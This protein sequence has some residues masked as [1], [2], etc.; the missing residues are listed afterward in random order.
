MLAILAI[1]DY[2]V[3]VNLLLIILGFFIGIYLIR[4]H[5]S[6]SSRKACNELNRPHE[7]VYT[8]PDHEELCCQVCGRKPGDY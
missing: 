7:W 5:A 2:S 8:P 6:E 3:L 1:F 4:S